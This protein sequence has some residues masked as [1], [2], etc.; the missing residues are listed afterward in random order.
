M[1]TPR[2]DGGMQ[3]QIDI[4]KTTPV[5]CE[6]CEKHYSNSSHL[7]RHK[8]TVHDGIQYSCHKCEYKVT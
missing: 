3:E 1:I 6:K 7:K 2:K 8:E 5:K 4:S